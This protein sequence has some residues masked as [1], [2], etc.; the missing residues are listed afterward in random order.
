MP[1]IKPKI[2]DLNLDHDQS[3]IPHATGLQK[4][5]FVPHGEGS[6]G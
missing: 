2:E 6:Y 3:R 5:A 4:N 1:E